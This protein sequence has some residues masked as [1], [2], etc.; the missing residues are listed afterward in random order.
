MSW[1]KAYESRAEFTDVA[2]R[3]ADKNSLP[4]DQQRQ[5]DVAIAGAEALLPGLGDG[6]ADVRVAISGHA[7]G[8][9]PT[10]NDQ[11]S[12]FVSHK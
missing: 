6:N 4:A 9:T 11:I 3:S 7:S 2:R 12:V 8:T 5:Y 10:M 1:S